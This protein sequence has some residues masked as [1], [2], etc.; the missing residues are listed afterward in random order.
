MAK[1]KHY[2]KGNNGKVNN[3]SLGISQV[4][5]AMHQQMLYELALTRIKWLNLPPG[6]DERFL[7]LT[8]LESGMCVIY[9]ANEE[10]TIFYCSKVVG[11]GGINNYYNWNKY[12]AIGLNGYQKHLDITNSTIIHDSK[13][14][15][16]SCLTYINV[17][18]ERLTNVDRIRDTNLNTQRNP[19]LITGPEEKQQEM[20]SF[21]RNI[22]SDE[23]AIF[24]IDEGLGN[25]TQINVLNTQTPLLHEDLTYAKGHLINEILSYMGIDN[26]GLN[27]AERMTTQEVD[28]INQVIEFRKL[29]YLEPRR[30][31]AKKLNEMF[32]LDIQ[33]VW[34]GD[35]ISKS[36]AFA[37]DLEKQAE[38]G[39]GFSE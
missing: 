18:A 4:T 32:G 21:Y 3:Q 5:Y 30:Q 19:Y 13:S 17:Y 8:L 37:H 36:Y 34:N 24:S 7:E 9:P 10:K 29:N 6:I 11:E 39:G 35:E 33:V 12:K 38:L 23:P 15:Q 28:I 20:R 1:K 26:S 14:R 22:V 25:E 31:A 16:A 2:S 27:K